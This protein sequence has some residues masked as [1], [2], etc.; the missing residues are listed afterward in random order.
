VGDKIP[1]FK[2]SAGEYS[3]TYRDGWRLTSVAF[4]TTLRANLAID[5]ESPP[6]SL[7]NT[8]DLGPVNVAQ[9]AYSWLPPPSPSPLSRVEEA[10]VAEQLPP[11]APAPPRYETSLA[12][13]EDDKVEALH[14]IA[15]SVVQQRQH[16]YVAILRHPLI[17][18]L[19]CLA[20]TVL[21]RRLATG[22]SSPITISLIL[23][24][25]ILMA[26]GTLRLLTTGY[27]REAESIG[28]WTWLQKDLPSID[29][30]GEDTVF[31]AHSTAISH[32]IGA[33]ILRGV[34]DLPAQYTSPNASSNQQRKRRQ[35]SR[36]KNAPVIGFIRGWA[37]KAQYQRQG[38]GT[39]L[40]EE[41]IRLCQQ[42]GWQGPEIDPEHANS[43]RHLPDFC[44]APLDR[45]EQRALGLL[46]RVKDDMGVGVVVSGKRRR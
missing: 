36:D 14:L 45:R 42:R 17:L 25:A 37:V 39:Q 31:L 33:L 22:Q 11:L 6:A 10:P 46:E 40:L 27:I 8:P 5:L 23:T 16:A 38:V 41:A 3:A 26:L 28:T 44:D 21:C 1:G 2:T 35:T 29:I 19:T 43:K 32:V 34:R 15:D 4:F 20:L 30:I 13:T 7:C 12:S 9:S 24:G 18:V